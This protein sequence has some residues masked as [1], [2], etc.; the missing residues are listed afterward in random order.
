MISTLDTILDFVDAF[1]CPLHDTV[2]IGSFHW[3]QPQHEQN[4]LVH[5]LRIR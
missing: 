2:N 3:V 1:L 5:I 4:Q